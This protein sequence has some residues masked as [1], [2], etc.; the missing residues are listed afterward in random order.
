MFLLHRLEFSSVNDLLQQHYKSQMYSDELNTY[1]IRV[2]RRKLWEDGCEELSCDFDVKKHLR[3]KFINEKG[4]D[5]GGPRHEFFFRMIGEMAKQNILFEGPDG[6]RTPTHNLLA[7]R[8]NK[9]FLMGKIVALSILNGGPA[10]KFFLSIYK[11]IFFM[12]I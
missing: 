8:Q 5:G 3:V 10:P 4:A 11:N 7:L 12:G 2:R 6:C 1:R 9:F